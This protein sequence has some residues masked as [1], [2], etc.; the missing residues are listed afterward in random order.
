MYTPP[1]NRRIDYHPLIWAGALSDTHW[2]WGTA[3]AVTSN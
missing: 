2:G 3:A 1:T